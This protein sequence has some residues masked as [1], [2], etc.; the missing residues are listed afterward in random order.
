MWKPLREASQSSTSA[1]WK[2][3]TPA[4]RLPLRSEISQCCQKLILREATVL[5][6]ERL[7]GRAC[8]PLS[9]AATT[10]CNNELFLWILNSARPVSLCL[11]LNLGVHQVGAT[12][13]P[14]VSVGWG[15]KGTSG[16]AWW[17]SPQQPEG[18]GQEKKQR[19]RMHGHAAKIKKQVK[20]RS[21]GREYF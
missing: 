17:Q 20:E 7:N 8:P 11:A 13:P 15:N 19:H 16:Q 21:G 18:H 12:P 6:P 5:L 10:S 1:H 9:S 3:G 4:L 14:H 2:A